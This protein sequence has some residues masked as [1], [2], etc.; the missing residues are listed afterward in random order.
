MCV[1]VLAGNW[2]SP[3]LC[4]CWCSAS[5]TSSSLGCLIHIRDQAGKSECTVS[6]FSTH[7]RYF[8]CYTT[9]Y[10]RFASASSCEKCTEQQ[11]HLHQVILLRPLAIHEGN[12]ILVHRANAFFLVAWTCLALDLLH[13]ILATLTKKQ[14]HFVFL[15]FALFFCLWKL[16]AGQSKHYLAS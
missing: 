8:L 6:C 13:N 10:E 7:F 3:L 11:T 1:C 5:T 16:S 15:T 12:A 14:K 4:S 2:Q 9:C